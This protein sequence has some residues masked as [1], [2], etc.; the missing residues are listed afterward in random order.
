MP[1]AHSSQIPGSKY[2]LFRYLPVAQHAS[3]LTRLQLS[4]IIER[5]QFHDS[6]LMQR[7]QEGVIA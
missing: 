7:R 3:T 2:R 1:L 6:R 4:C 5:S